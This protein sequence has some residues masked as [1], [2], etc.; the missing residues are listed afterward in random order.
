M[1]DKIWAFLQYG[2]VSQSEYTIISPSIIKHNRYTAI[3]FSSI[4]CILFIIKTITAKIQNNHPLIIHYYLIGLIASIAIILIAFL[5]KYKFDLIFIITYIGQTFFLTYACIMDIYIKPEKNSTFFISMIMLLPLIFIDKPKNIIS[6]TSGFILA[7]FI[8]NIFMIK[9]KNIVRE[10]ISNT[11]IF[12]TLGL[13]SSLLTTTNKIKEFVLENKLNVMS[14]VDKLTGLNNRNYYEWMLNL[15][16]GMC[17]ESL[18]CIYIDVNGLH[19]LNNT[20]G[21]EAGD[22]M[23][24]YIAQK[25]Q[26]IFG[27]R[28][29]YRIGGDEYVA[30]LLDPETSDIE[31]KITRLKNDIENQNYHIAVGCDKQRSEN[32]DINQLIKNAEKRMYNNKQDYYEKTNTHR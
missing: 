6:L 13:T 11:L 24:Q 27:K 29:T 9:D 15:Y 8:S 17:H 18:C 21:H 1:K 30:F 31:K 4:A 28:H 22:R 16:P 7:F 23:L 2:S 32:L 14:T 5:G 10:N 3:M 12:G 26:E 20:Q 19:T 25:T